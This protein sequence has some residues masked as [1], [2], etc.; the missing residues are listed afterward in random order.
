MWLFVKNRIGRGFC[1][2]CYIVIDSARGEVVLSSMEQKGLHKQR[3][4][5][6]YIGCGYVGADGVTLWRGTK[7]ECSRAIAAFDLAISYGI[8]QAMATYIARRRAEDRPA[9]PPGK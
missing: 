9:G 4:G 1:S 3:E 7:E 5:G 6:Q 2:G 8:G